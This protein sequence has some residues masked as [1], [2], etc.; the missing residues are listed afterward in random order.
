LQGN[1][2]VRSKKFWQQIRKEAGKP[3]TLQYE[4]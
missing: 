4:I 1:K 3:L 2:A